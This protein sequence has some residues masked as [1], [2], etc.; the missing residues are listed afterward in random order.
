MHSLID[1]LGLKYVYADATGPMARSFSRN[2]RHWDLESDNIILIIDDV[3][4]HTP[5]QMDW[6]LHY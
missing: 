2:Y 1:G 3:Q 6:L 5:G 4:A